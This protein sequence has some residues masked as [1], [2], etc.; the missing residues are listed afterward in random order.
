MFIRKAIKKNRKTQKEYFSYQLMESIRTERGPRQ[1]LVLNLGCDLPVSDNERKEL[2]NRIEE[3]QSGTS[4][5]FPYPEHIEKF[6]QTYHK[7]L[8]RKQYNNAALE[9]KSGEIKQDKDFQTVDLNSLNHENA[10]SV[11]MEHLSLETIKK[12]KLDSLFQ[13][14]GLTERQVDVAL[15]VIIGKLCYPS[16]ERATL[17]W[18]K[19]CSGVDELIG[20]DFTRLSK[21]LVYQVADNLLQNKAEIESHLE[22][23]ESDLF[24][25]DETVILYD[26]SNTYFE[27]GAKG[28]PEALRGKSKEN[29]S[30]CPLITLGLVLNKE[31]FPKKSRMLPGNISE[32]KTLKEALNK[33]ETPSEKKPTVVFDAGIATKENLA[34]LREEGYSYIVASRS[35]SCEIS[36]EITLQ[37]IKDKKD[38]VVKAAKVNDPES[39]E[40]LLYCHSSAREEK[41]KSMRSL[42]EKRLEEDLRTASNAISKKGGTKCYEKVM[43]RIGRI[44]EKHK[45][46]AKYY[47]IEV[48]PDE[49]KSKAMEINW[50]VDENGLENRFQGGYLLKAYGLDW[51]SE[52]LWSTYIMLTK[53]EESFRCLK[54]DL[55]L[56]PIFHQVTRRV[57]GHLF[58]TVIAYHV[59]HTILYQLQNK[60]INMRWQTLHRELE[61]QIRVTTTMKLEDGRQV[62][63][64]KTTTADHDQKEIYK[65]LGIE[66]CPG[67]S[68]KV[69]A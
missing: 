60:S 66:S 38:N 54:T 49:S 48:K 46:I 20:A 59:M 31:G 17:D 65:A 9:T 41:E 37:T 7:I 57:E 24:S 15:G 64:R 30:D 55:G 32:P 11:G 61:N 35:R 69:F 29:R 50:E 12:L 56:R 33:L 5:L 42:K 8:C 28:T 36:D 34:Y 6:A 45:S 58:L 13:G 14:F 51:S 22:K 23:R 19:R 16:S 68:V 53:V 4:N 25:F 1:R 40:T 67:K 52:K 47:K 21:D 39:G 3:L 43:E 44:K 27:G 63:I 62:H 10:R 26:L 18:L 2:A